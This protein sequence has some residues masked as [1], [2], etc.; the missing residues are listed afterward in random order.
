ME[1]KPNVQTPISVGGQGRY[2]IVRSSDAPVF[3]SAD[4][5]KPQRLESGDRIDITVFNEMYLE[6]H[7]PQTVAFDYQVSDIDFRPASTSGLVVQRI[8]EPIEFSATVRVGDGLKV[9]Q[10]APQAPLSKPDRVIRPKTKERIVSPSEGFKSVMVQV[11]SDEYTVLRV[12]GSNV[13]AQCGLMV[14]GYKDATGVISV[15]CAGDIWVYNA[16]NAPAIIAL[17]GVK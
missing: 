12:G 10:I 1:L 11:I 7:Q 16:S 2:L 8:I 13:G 17:M 15:D 5:L 4:N 3:I 14:S 9:E 6:H